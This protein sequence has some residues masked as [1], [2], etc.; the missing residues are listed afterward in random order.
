MKSPN[1]DRNGA[2]M[3]CS[4]AGTKLDHSR[5]ALEFLF[6]GNRIG[7]CVFESCIV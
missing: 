1:A 5:P 6:H 4:G 7:F 2:A 3:N